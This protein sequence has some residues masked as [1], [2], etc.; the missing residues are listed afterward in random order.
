MTPGAFDEGM[1]ILSASYPSLSMELPTLKVWRKLLDDLDDNPFLNAVYRLCREEKQ[2]YP[3]TNIVALIRERA[4]TASSGIVALT[5]L[6]DAMQKVG[7]YRSV[8]FDDP[9]IHLTVDRMG[10]WPKLC[11]MGNEEWKFLR[12]EFERIY[13]AV[14]REPVLIDQIPKRL[15]GVIELSNNTSG[16]GDRP[17]QMQIYG[18]ERKAL[19]WTGQE[20]ALPQTKGNVVR[21]DLSRIGRPL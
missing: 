2:L 8:V 15:C 12:R 11:G 16:H 6:E 21:L 14:C 13:D 17:I 7:A 9:L 3:G 18:D 10:G 1:A 4:V 20:K 19:E 5:R